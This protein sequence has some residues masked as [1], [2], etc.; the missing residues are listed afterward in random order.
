MI[1]SY[2]E[3]IIELVDLVEHKVKKFTL[4]KGVIDTTEDSLITDVMLVA[5]KECVVGMDRDI[6]QLKAKFQ[7]TS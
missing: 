7:K 6:A 2:Q 4:S 3:E 1:Q 5:A